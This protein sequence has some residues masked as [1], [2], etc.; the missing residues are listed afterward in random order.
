MSSISLPFERQIRHFFVG[1]AIA[2]ETDAS[3]FLSGAT[4]GEVQIFGANGTTADTSG[5]FYLA[6]KNQKGSVSTSD[7]ITPADVT[8]FATRAPRAKVGKTQTFTLGGAPTV[9]VSYR[10][11]G[12]V[13]YGTTE[14]NF[15]TF[16]AEKTA[17]TGDTATTLLVD[18][19]KQIA[20]QLANSIH[21][22][23]VES[24]TD[25]I[26]G[27]TTAEKNKYFTLSVSGS[28][29]TVAEKDWILTDYKTGLKTLD[30]VLWNFEVQTADSE[31][32]NVTKAETAQVFPE[33]QGYQM[34]ELERYLVGHR[35]E[36]DLKDRTLEFDRAYDT[37]ISSTYYTIDLKYHDVSIRDPKLSDKMLTIVADNLTA[38]NAIGNALDARIASVTWVDYV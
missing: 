1:D 33:G 25:T 14:E 38:I 20:D 15:I 27:A 9:G 36:F 10:L 23:T 26:E 5:D 19:A 8:Y 35:A 29:L 22:D 21:T 16:W 31:A 32:S 2:T 28:V 11:V 3:A 18:L 4:I 13:N 37:V 12:K 30:Q 7:L 34:R 24:G 17:V 6:K